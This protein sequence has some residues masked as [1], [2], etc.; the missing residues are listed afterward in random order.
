MPFAELVVTKAVPQTDT[1]TSF[2]QQSH[3]A[4]CYILQMQ[5]LNLLLIIVSE[6]LLCKDEG[7][8]MNTAKVCSRQP[9]NSPL[10]NFKAQTKTDILKK[11]HKTIGSNQKSDN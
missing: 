4:M 11:L 7:A 2:C 10:W 5:N 6:C 8:I 1:Y 9:E 3:N